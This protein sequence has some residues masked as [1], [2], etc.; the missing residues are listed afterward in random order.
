MGSLAAA[1]YDVETAGVTFDYRDCWLV[2]VE[3]KFRIGRF[4]CL[5]AVKT[6]LRRRVRSCFSVYRGIITVAN[7]AANQ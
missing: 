5:A 6:R 2:S 3:K 7:S 1:R 4:R